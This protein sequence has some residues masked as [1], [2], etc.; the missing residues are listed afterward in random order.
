MTT[1]GFNLNGEFGMRM[2]PQVATVWKWVIGGGAA[3]GGRGNGDG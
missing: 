1:D 2:T 3:A